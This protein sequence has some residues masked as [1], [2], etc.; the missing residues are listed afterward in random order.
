MYISLKH[1]LFVSIFMIKFSVYDKRMPNFIHA[2][3]SLHYQL[4][5]SHCGNSFHYF[6]L[7][8]GNGLVMVFP[9]WLFSSIVITFVTI[10]LSSIMFFI[11]FFYFIDKLKVF[12]WL[13]FCFFW[14]KNFQFECEPRIYAA[15][16]TDKSLLEDFNNFGLCWKRYDCLL[17][18]SMNSAAKR[19]G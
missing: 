19:A 14:E 18:I 8:I 13:I 12:L 17:Q 2:Q 16:S 1:L 4:E 10:L 6:V 7:P 9:Y 15:K 5:F 11:S 3:D